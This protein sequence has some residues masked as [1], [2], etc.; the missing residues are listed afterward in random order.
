[1]EAPPA[2]EMSVAPYVHTVKSKPSRCLSWLSVSA[3]RHVLF[4][5]RQ[6]PDYRATSVTP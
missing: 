1:M 3:S 4:V 2:Q 5:Y 6:L